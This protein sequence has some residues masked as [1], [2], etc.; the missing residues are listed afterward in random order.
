MELWR[1]LA[2]NHWFTIRVLG[3]EV[4]LC[5]R[6]SGYIM[7]FLAAIA[8]HSLMGSQ[9]FRSLPVNLQ[10]TVCL[11]TLLPLAV[12]WLT[13]SWGWR[14]SSNGLRLLTGVALGTGVFLFSLV[15]SAHSLKNSFFV[16]TAV[17][18]VF[19]GLAGDILDRPFSSLK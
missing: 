14:K 2:H 3:R 8:L 1:L 11:L 10:F 12:D 18:I 4:R 16:S 9:L 6:C 7:G 15:D 17:A 5:A 19:F 13:Q